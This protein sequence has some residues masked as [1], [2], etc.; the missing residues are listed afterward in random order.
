ME[1]ILIQNVEK[2]GRRGDV[3]RVREGFGRNFLLPRKLALPSTRANQKFVEEQKVRAAKRREKEKTAARDQAEKL[4]KVAL[5]ISVRAGEKDKL[6]GSVTSEDIRQALSDAGY[7]FEKKQ[8]HIKEPIR[9][10][11]KHEITV[12]LYPEVKANVSVEVA[13]KKTKT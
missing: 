8:I 12:E 6:F 9:S 11:G 5:K 7:P 10:L 4:K 2:V 1:V 3:V 13:G